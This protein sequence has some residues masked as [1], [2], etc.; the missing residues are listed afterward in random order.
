MNVDQLGILSFYNS[1]L[2]KVEVGE[3][4]VEYQVKDFTNV[5]VLI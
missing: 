3:H 4:F 2:S 5:E 1:E